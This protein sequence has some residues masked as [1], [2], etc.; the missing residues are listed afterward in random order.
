L[1]GTAAPV[2]SP[3]KGSGGGELNGRSLP[4]FIAGKDAII[5]TRRPASWQALSATD[6]ALLDFLR[7]RGAFCDLPPEVVEHKLIGFFRESGRFERLTRV[8]A[9]EPPCVRAMLGAIGQQLGL[10]PRRLLVLRKDL[11]P[12]SRFDFGILTGLP[13]AKE[14]QVKQNKACRLNGMLVKEN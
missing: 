7:N 1:T 4:K 3:E 10:L 8:A 9:S 14:W 2:G 11:N 12:L 6:A 5:H 13:D